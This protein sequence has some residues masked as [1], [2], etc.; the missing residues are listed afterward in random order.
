MCAA[1]GATVINDFE[2]P[3]N[4]AERSQAAG[5]TTTES[6]VS[7]GTFAPI[8]APTRVYQVISETLC[9]HIARAG[10]V[11]GD[12][13]PSERELARQLQVSRSSVRQAMTE[14]RVMGI[15]SVR[16]GDGAYLRRRPEERVP[17]IDPRVAEDNPDYTQL[18]EARQVLERTVASLAAQRRTED[19]LHAMRAG[20]EEMRA[21]IK[22]GD[23]GIHG[24]RSFHEA[25]AAASHNEVLLELLN[26]LA[27]SIRRLSV[28]SLSRPG[29][30]ERSLENHELIYEAIA[31]RDAESAERLMGEH[32]RITG[33]I[34]ADPNDSGR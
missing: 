4:S 17:P 6:R 19:D 2:H 32:L 10:L 26:G 1:L 7:H 22:A 33:A 27:A 15:I 25:V 20:I 16:H 28:A 34:G 12:A 21:Q 3:I 5:E 13:L 14:L 24:N 8:A 31:N 30:A 18:Y 11:P 29:Q 23:I 9:D